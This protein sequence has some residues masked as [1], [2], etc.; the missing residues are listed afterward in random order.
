MRGFL[1]YLAGC[2]TVA[3]LTLI[4]PETARWLVLGLF[5]AVVYVVTAVPRRNQP[6]RTRREARVRGEASER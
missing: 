3:G 1:A 2:A 4:D 5:V 6:S